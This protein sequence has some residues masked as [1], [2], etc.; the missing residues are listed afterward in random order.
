MMM[1]TYSIK[2]VDDVTKQGKICILDLD[3]QVF[4]FVTQEECLVIMS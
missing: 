1:V 3:R 2:A 4:N